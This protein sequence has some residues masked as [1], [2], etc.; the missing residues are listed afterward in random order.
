MIILLLL[1][2][3]IGT[4]LILNIKDNKKIKEI[5]LATAMINFIISIIMWNKFDYSCCQPQ[6]LIRFTNTITAGVDGISLL[7]LLLT[8]FIIVISILG[9]WNIDKN[10]KYFINSL[11]ILESILVGVFVILDILIFYIF[12]ETSLIPMF[13]LIGLFGSNSQGY[14]K[15]KE[16][17]ELTRIYATYQFFL[18]TLA[19]SLLMLLAILIL[20]SFSGTYDYIFISSSYLLPSRQFIL[21]LS[22]SFSKKDM[23]YSLIHSSNNTLNNKK[24]NTNLNTIPKDLECKS[25]VVYGSNRRSDKNFTLLSSSTHIN[26]W[27][28]TGFSDAESSFQISITENK[29]LN[30]RWRGRAFYTIGLH[31]RDF[32]LLQKIQYF[33]GGV[34]NIYINSK[35]DVVEYKVTKLKD[36]DI[37]IRHFE[38]YPLQSAKSIDYKLWKEC[39][40][41]IKA[42]AH[43]TQSGLE[44]IV[45]IRA[46]INQG[47]SEKLKNYFQNVVPKIRPVYQINKISLNPYWVT[48]FSDG[49]SSFYAPINDNTNQ[50]RVVYSISLNERELPLLKKI[51]SFFYGIGYIGKDV[52][53]QAFYYKVSRREDISSIIIEHFN[54]YPLISKKFKDFTIWLQ[55]VKL[56][57]LRN[58]LTPEGLIKIKFL[59]NKLNK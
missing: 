47:L 42:K 58:H 41:L 46:V 54:Y 19:G 36:L 21:W 2:P 14:K 17:E 31:N 12:F 30:T 26:P 48:G 53:N 3:I 18:M 35:K 34:G 4:L 10:I 8:T 51:Q 1:V 9:G 43:L 24:I 32:F 40:E 29:T 52:N 38:K 55:I 11:L 5:G 49:D 44:K 25:L 6:F 28:I 56:M 16:K 45:S 7:F 59:K 57:E 33:F 37:I 39:I 13:L 15:G 27:Y 23:T 22:L 20:Y 50:I